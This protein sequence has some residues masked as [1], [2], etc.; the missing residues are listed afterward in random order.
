MGDVKENWKSF[1]CFSKY[2]LSAVK[3]SEDR[4]ATV[5][6]VAFLHNS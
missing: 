1:V 4:A 3:R 5:S 2:W 6:N